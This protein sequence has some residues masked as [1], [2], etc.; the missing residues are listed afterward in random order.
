MQR[1]LAPRLLPHAVSFVVVR[2]EVHLGSEHVAKGMYISGRGQRQSL[3]ELS[4]IALIVKGLIRPFDAGLSCPRH[5]GM[6]NRI[7]DLRS[8]EI[9]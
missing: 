2:R 6:I 3:A 1:V 9:P 5:L 7:A 8:A 4:P